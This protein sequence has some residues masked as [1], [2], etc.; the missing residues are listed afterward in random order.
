M[1]LSSLPRLPHALVV[2]KLEMA[3]KSVQ[4]TLAEM[5]RTGTISLEDES[6][7]DWWDTDP[8]EGR[9]LDEEE[10]GHEDGADRGGGGTWNLPLGFVVVYVC[11]LGDGRERPPI[12]KS[13]VGRTSLLRASCQTKSR[14]SEL[15]DL[16]SWIDSPS[17]LPFGWKPTSTTS[18][19]DRSSGR[20]SSQERY[21]S[22]HLI[23][24]TVSK[25]FLSVLIVAAAQDI[26]HLQA[27]C[28]STHISPRLHNY[29]FS[30]LTAARHHPSLDAALLTAR[31]VADYTDLVRAS[32]VVLGREESVTVSSAASPSS[33]L[34]SARV[35]SAS[36]ADARRMVMSG[37]EHR[38][39]VRE[40]GGE[41][42]MASLVSTAVG[43]D[44][45]NGA[46]VSR[47]VRQRG[48]HGRS[49]VS[50]LG[51]EG[52]NEEAG[53]DAEQSSMEDGKGASN[54]SEDGYEEER[55]TVQEILQ[56]ILEEV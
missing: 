23:T 19:R 12:H 56:S 54:E 34:S 7:D 4:M 35:L 15:T 18:R 6:T 48:R 50:A 30:L 28:A 32:R 3:K 36:D 17:A 43:V 44:E 13:L 22:H 31:A 1:S 21:V 14:P 9:E 24:P 20:L 29:I 39:R 33:M 46:D 40:G 53:Y 10:A 25:R 42:V 38:L 2:S 47:K 5:L 41:Y 45:S 11:P 16:R 27:L 55:H 26:D 52:P 51:D 8:P 49:T 37:L